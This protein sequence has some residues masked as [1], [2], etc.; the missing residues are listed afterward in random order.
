MPSGQVLCGD[1]FC[2]IEEGRGS[3]RAR[4][5]GLDSGS[6]GCCNTPRVRIPSPPPQ[7]I[8]DQREGRWQVSQLTATRAN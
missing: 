8:L 5:K 4:S 7:Q 6:S 2:D 1:G 3:A